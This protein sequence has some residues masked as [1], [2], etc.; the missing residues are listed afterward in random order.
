MNR[1]VILFCLFAAM[2]GLLRAQEPKLVNCRTLEAAG[3]FVGPDEVLDGD[4]VCQKLKPGAKEEPKAQPQ[5]PL[6]GAD[7]PDSQPMS[8]AEAARA[9]RKKA[10]SLK[11]AS[12]GA[13]VPTPESVAPAASAV[14]PAKANPS[15]DAPSKPAPETAP[16]E[17][18][19][20]APSAAAVPEPVREAA[21]VAASPVSTQPAASAAAPASTESAPAA[22]QPTSV[23]VP[24][25][26]A[27]AIHIRRD[28]PVAA[29]TPSERPEKDT[30]FSDA[31]AVETPAIPANAGEPG[32]RNA[33]LLAGTGD[34]RN[35]ERAVKLGVFERPKEEAADATSEAHNTNFLPGDTEGFQE[36]QRPEC[37]KNITLGSMRNEKL[38]LGTPGW[39]A[40]WI[41]KNRKH[42]PAICFSDT[43]MRG[44][45]NYLIVFYAMAANGEAAANANAAMPMPDA[46]PAGGVGSF[47]TK[48]GSTW[49]YAVDRSVGV[50][51]LTTDEADEPHSQA[52]VWYATAYTEDG[53]PVAERWPEQA[54]HAVKGDEVNP[55]RERTAQ[56]ERERI[57]EELLTAMVEDLRKQ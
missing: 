13:T 14:E 41:E 57:S 22:V 28:A 4:K 34:D 15:A 26:T 17:S 55:K 50:T 53:M 56:E 10:T 36:G 5:K 42:M 20:A 37:T 40:K 3:Y 48:Y 29:G 39:A 12:V 51:V 1:R 46:K 16:V 31:N 9:N 54:R 33:V 44:A 49:H 21:P 7:V 18:A 32:V 8:V 47:T 2:P 38:V 45:R 6:P 25:A 24:A 27:P 23:P 19:P 52:R 35:S 30:G 43:P 11:D